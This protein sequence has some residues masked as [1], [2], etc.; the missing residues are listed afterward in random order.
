MIKLGKVF[1]IIDSETIQVM[2]IDEDELYTVKGDRLNIS[3]I[4]DLSEESG[5]EIFIDFDDETMEMVV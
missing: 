1:N 2:D 3:G 5:G 4:K